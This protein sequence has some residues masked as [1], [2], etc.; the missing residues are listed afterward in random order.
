MAASKEQRGAS[1]TAF[2][3]MPRI[4]SRQIVDTQPYSM[5]NSGK[6]ELQGSF[7]RLEDMSGKY[8]TDWKEYGAGMPALLKTMPAMR[9]RLYGV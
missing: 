6:R 4:W 2:A 7:I 3:T 8:R 5:R 1:R 9:L